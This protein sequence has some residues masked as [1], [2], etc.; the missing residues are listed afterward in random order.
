LQRSSFATAP[1]QLALMTGAFALGT[2]VAALA[3]AQL[4]TACAF[5]Q[6]AFAAALVSV[7]L[8]AP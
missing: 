7:L 6:L 4:G 5:G 3:G 8:R 1:A 2:A